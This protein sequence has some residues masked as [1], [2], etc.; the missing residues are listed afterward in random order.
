MKNYKLYASIYK[1]FEDASSDDIKFDLR[2]VYQA[3]NCIIANITD[4][5]KRKLTE[6]EDLIRFYEQ[7]DD[8]IR[9]LSYKMLVEGINDKYKDFD[10]NQKAI[11]REYINNVSNTNSL[12]KFLADKIEE[13]KNAL[14]E[15]SQKIT[16]SDVMRIK[17]NEV[18]K[19]LDNV[20]PGTVV[21]DDQIMVVLLSYELLKEIKKQIENENKVI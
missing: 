2:E 6:E 18:V 1:I 11:L 12:G 7:Q 21:K 13:V 10:D 8:E 4:N 19:Q 16:D 5:P 9:L 3:K 20:K 17:V 15:A 14:D